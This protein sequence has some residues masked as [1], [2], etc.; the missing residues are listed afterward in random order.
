MRDAGPGPDAGDASGAPGVGRAIA[1]GVREGVGQAFRP[2]VR[3]VD[4]VGGHVLL[5]VRALAWLPRRPYRIGNYLEAADYIGFGSLPII[6]LVGAF[7]GAVTSLQMVNAFRVFGL[8]TMSGGVTGKSLALELA[9]VLTCLML[10][11]RAGAGVATELGTMRIT[12]QIDALETM[13]INPVQFLVLPRVVM[14][15]LTAPILTMLFF[16]V[17]MIGAYIVAVITLNVDHGQFL[18]N[19]ELY[20]KPVD[21][22]QGVIKSGVFGLAVMLIAC[23]QGY[24]ASGGG[25]GVG[26]ATTRAV[27]AGSVGVLVLDYFVSDVL[28]ALLPASR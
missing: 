27:V 14:G 23:Y 4:S 18:S 5:L 13:A 10:A 19:F 8:E 16:I 15:T 24:N 28:L 2:V 7:T 25:R 6:L 21:V 20:V 11:A 22:A 12:E 17:G 1:S 26:L 9:P 3:F